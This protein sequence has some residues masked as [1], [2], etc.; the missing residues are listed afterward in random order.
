MNIKQAISNIESHEF[1]V[2]VNIASDLKTFLKVVQQEEAVLWFGK[3]LAIYE[4]RLEI[5]SR[6]YELSKSKIDL[7]YENQWDT[8]LAVYLWLLDNRDPIIAKIAAE[9][10]SQIPQCWWAAKLSRFI[11]FEKQLY[12]D[13]KTQIT[14]TPLTEI[15]FSPPPINFNNDTGEIQVF[16]SLFSA[17][18][19]VYRHKYGFIIIAKNPNDFVS[20]GSWGKR[21]PYKVSQLSSETNISEKAFQS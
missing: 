16:A 5:L 8:A 17:I 19:E 11:L 21:T 3:Q 13:T 9:V 14:S 7:R 4:M 15:T 1:A 6:I 12:S 10:A 20:N 18:D 2:R